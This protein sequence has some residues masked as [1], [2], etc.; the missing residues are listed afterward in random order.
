MEWLVA[1]FMALTGIGSAHDTPG[2][3]FVYLVTPAAVSAPA[4]LPQA[5]AP[6][7]A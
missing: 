2:G 4:A 6:R 7:L 3:P 1:F 5:E